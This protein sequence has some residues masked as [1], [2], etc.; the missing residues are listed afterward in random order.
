MPN[1]IGGPRDG[2]VIEEKHWPN[3]RMIVMG[4]FLGY[5]TDGD[6]RPHMVFEE[7]LYERQPNRDYHFVRSIQPNHTPPHEE[8]SDNDDTPLFVE[9]PHAH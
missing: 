2:Q 3:A 8:D 5:R 7:L 9:N 1:L 4:S 6:G